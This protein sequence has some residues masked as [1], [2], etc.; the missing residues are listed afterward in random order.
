MND[1]LSSNYW[2]PNNGV[3][4]IGMMSNDRGLMSDMFTSFY[5]LPNNETF[6]DLLREKN[7]NFFQYSSQIT[8]SR[9]T[10]IGYFRYINSIDFF[11]PLLF[12]IL[13]SICRCQFEKMVLRLSPQKVQMKN[14]HEPRK[15]E[16]VTETSWR[17]FAYSFLVIY[18]IISF[19][20]KNYFWNTELCFSQYPQKRVSLDL[21]FYYMIQIGLYISLAISQFI[22][23]KRKDFWVMFVHHIVTL[24]LLYSSLA[25]MMLEI[26]STIAFLHD[27]SDILLELAKLLK[28]FKL[29]SLSSFCFGSFGLS[30]FLLRILLYPW[31]ILRVTISK[32]LTVY[33]ESWPGL[34]IINGWLGILFVLHCIWFRMILI[35]AKKLWVSG[36]TEDIRSED[37]SSSSEMDSTSNNRSRKKKKNRDFFNNSFHSFLNSFPFYFLRFYD[38]NSMTHKKRDAPSNLKN[39]HNKL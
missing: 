12:A 2:L 32:Q 25:I 31:H 34:A 4:P 10:A 39:F 18:A 17:L 24:L 7:E 28:Y 9:G 38:P 22:D 14:H 6:A 15:Q 33:T 3:F 35:G 30:W 37:E 23:V 8:I 11:I 29:T 27:I 21:W 16:K 36:E 20:Q 26:G 1:F 13:I 19:S 5:W